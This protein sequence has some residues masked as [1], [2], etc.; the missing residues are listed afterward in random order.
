RA[1]T[2]GS[3][4]PPG[5]CRRGAPP[6][7][8]PRPRSAPARGR[9]SSR[10]QVELRVVAEYP[11]D[12]QR[13]Q[14]VAF[15]GRVDGVDED[16]E[17]AVVRALHGPR[18]DLARAEVEALGGELLHLLERRIQRGQAEKITEPHLLVKGA[19]R[20][21]RLV[22]EAG[23][24]RAA[25][26]AAVVD[27]VD[28]A[29]LDAGIDRRAMLDLEVELHLRR[30]EVV[31]VVEPRQAFSGEALVEPGADVDL[32]RLAFPM[33]VLHAALVPPAALEVVVVP[34]DELVVERLMHVELD[35]LRPH[36]ERQAERRQR[37]LGRV[38]AGPAVGDH[39]HRPSKAVSRAA[40]PA[41]SYSTPSRASRPVPGPW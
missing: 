25:Q 22:I 9:P 40:W 6:R 4:A 12:A 24:E 27:H 11:V 16:L 18:G 32:L 35:R 2:P 39:E 13:V 1:P 36:L 5:P 8:G 17:A 30:H 28:H 21:Q 15:R 41:S 10:P 34:D 7:P 23:D 37:V 19:H 29:L 20:V 33:D 31:D 26:A 38:A 3:R 14:P